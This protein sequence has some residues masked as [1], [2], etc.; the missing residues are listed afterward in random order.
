[1]IWPNLKQSMEI[2][3]NSTESWF[4]LIFS[5][6]LLIQLIYL[7]L[8][9][10]RFAFNKSKP[11]DK[12]ISLP[13]SVV[14]CAKNEFPN[15]KENLPLILNQ[16]YPDFEVVVVN[17][18][19]D[20]ETIFLLEDLDH[21]YERL[22]VVTIEKDF[23]FFKG[24]KFPLALGIKSAKN[25]YLLLT[26]ADCAPGGKHWISEMAKGFAD[27]REV[28]LGYGKLN[29][30]GNLIN[31]VIRF[32]TAF[33]ALQYFSL[34]LWGSPYMGVG[35]NLAYKKSLFIENKG[36][37][38]HYNILSGDDDLFINKVANRKNTAITLSPGSFTHSEAKQ[39]FSAWWRQKRRHL[40]TG[41]YYKASHKLWLG[42]FSISYL[43]WLILGIVLLIRGYLIV[44]V[45]SLLAIRVVS[46]L[47]IMKKTFDQLK[48]KK[49]LVI[50][51][52][53]ELFL[54]II[55]PVIVGVNQVFKESRWK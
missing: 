39:S 8:I 50:S 11:T 20:D 54:I 33:T 46:H 2:H 55:Y 28:V 35:R 7:W 36:F 51:P 9:F 48:E 43:L 3:F 44:W 47:I 23:N 19:S 38:S 16:D 1:M 18:A 53:I 21:E 6:S 14:I 49:L 29:E 42:L 4:F 10:G 30:S 24:K 25:E 17:D 37:I 22:K 32:E 52:L 31:K 40:S 45:L 26:D 15:L 41:R 27:S 13:V 34:A 5:V 12:K